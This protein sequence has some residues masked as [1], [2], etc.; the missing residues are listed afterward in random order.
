MAVFSLLL[1]LHMVDNHVWN[2][3]LSH[4]LLF[5]GLSHLFVI[6]PT[7]V[8]F[9][10]SGNRGKFGGLLDQALSGRE[11]LYNWLTNYL[12]V[13][14]DPPNCPQQSCCW[15]CFLSLLSSL[16]HFQHHLLSSLLSPAFTVQ[17]LHCLSCLSMHPVSALYSRLLTFLFAVFHS[18]LAVF[19][20]TDLA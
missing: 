1:C 3:S 8:K 13:F 5:F 16:L 19:C 9:I 11:G 6:H 2:V 10:R 20:S 12:A 15:P 4:S 17:P 7:L 14:Q 18:T